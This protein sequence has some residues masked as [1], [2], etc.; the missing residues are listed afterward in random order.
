MRRCWSLIAPWLLASV[1]ATAVAASDSPPPA[2]RSIVTVDASSPVPRPP[3][4]YDFLDATVDSLWRAHEAIVAIHSAGDSD[5][6]RTVAALEHGVAEVAV[7]SRRLRAFATDPYKP[8]SDAL[9]SAF[10]DIETALR[11]KL[12]MREQLTT[13]SDDRRARVDRSLDDAEALYEE[14]SAALG[15]AVG[16]AIGSAVIPDPRDPGGR[17]ALLL[18]PDEWTALVGSL[19]SR[20][21]ALADGRNEATGPKQAA[22][23]MLNVLGQNWRLAK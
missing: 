19:T 15:N 17:A 16:V 9:V 8:F 21:G 10:E 22:A 11:L 18:S 20:F 4:P 23:V 7:A 3:V 12:R 2:Q 5:A 6:D 1:T 13:A 14:G